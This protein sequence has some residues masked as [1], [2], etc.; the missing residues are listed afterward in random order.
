M[1]RAHLDAAAVRCPACLTG[2]VRLATIVDG[3][4]DDVRAG[5]LHCTNP[6][7][8]REFPILD[9]V[10]WLVPDPRDFLQQNAGPILER[11]D[12]DGFM[13]GVLADGIG[14]ATAFDAVRQH[15]SSY[16]WGH[17]GDRAGLG[18]SGLVGLVAAVTAQLT[19]L[20]DGPI[21]EVGS[22]MGRASVALAAATGRRVYGVDL[23]VAMLRSAQRL[24]RERHAR[25]PLRRSGVVYDVVDVP[26]DDPLDAVDFW[27]ADAR[28][29]PFPDGS[30]AGMVLINVLDTL[31][32]PYAFLARL[33]E[34]LAP[35][36]VCVMV[37]PYDWSTAVTA[38]DQWLGGH[39]ARAFAGGDPAG[40]VRGLLDG[41]HPGAIAGLSLVG[42]ADDLPWIVRLH[43]RAAMNYR[44]H[45]VAVRRAR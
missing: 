14:P 4:D 24:L 25:F 30:I 10:P 34:V 23:H 17:W 45:L 7:C 41:S 31:V 13:A 22:A 29:L 36:G 6:A 18:E 27:G 21:V 39:S 42:E 38:L 32:E 26:V 43:D 1:R 37:Q 15:R 40:V 11:D 5:T 3:N 8:F 9:G 35:G 12:L 16:G 20:P 19:A 2:G 28:Q 33:P 44:C